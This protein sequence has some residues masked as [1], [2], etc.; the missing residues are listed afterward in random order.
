[1]KWIVRFIRH[2]D[3]EQLEKYGEP[4]IADFLTELALCGEV[5][6]GTQNQAFSAC[7]F[8]DSKVFGRELGF[9]NSLRAKESLYLP[10]VLTKSDVAELLAKFSWNFKRTMFLLMYGRGLRHHECRTLRIKDVCFERSE[11]LVRNGK[12]EKDRVTVL[13]ELAIDELRQ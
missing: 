1:V 5:V 13:P 11:I 8:L 2:V 6:A 4:E 10:V 9:V 3:D 7:K 12:G